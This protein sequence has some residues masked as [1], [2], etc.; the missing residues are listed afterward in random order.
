MQTAPSLQPVFRSEV[1]KKEIRK[2]AKK[3]HFVTFMTTTVPHDQ[4]I[5]KNDAIVHDSLRHRW[6]RSSRAVRGTSWLV[7]RW[8]L[9]NGQK[10]EPSQNDGGRVTQQVVGL[11]VQFLFIYIH[12][13]GVPHCGECIWAILLEICRK[14]IQQDPKSNPESNPIQRSQPI[15]AASYPNDSKIRIP[16]NI[17]RNPESEM[18]HPPWTLLVKSCSIPHFGR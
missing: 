5:P 9:G 15:P 6:V 17:S 2:S 14:I 4:K 18:F 8:F 16:D 12:I 11:K 7:S 3:S 10:S 13:F 1:F